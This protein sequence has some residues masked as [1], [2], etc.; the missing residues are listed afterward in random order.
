MPEI[1]AASRATIVYKFQEKLYNTNCMYLIQFCAQTVSNTT[2]HK[3]YIIQQLSES[4]Y[5]A[6]NTTVTIIGAL[7]FR[8]NAGYRYTKMS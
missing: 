8:V 4:C 6:E 5:V 1:I 3:L 2:L 7:W